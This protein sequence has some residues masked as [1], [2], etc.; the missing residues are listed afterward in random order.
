MA[1]VIGPTPPGIGRDESRDLAHARVDVADQPGLGA[2]DADVEHGGP[3][4]YVLRRDQP[5][6]AGRGH[7]D[8]GAAQVGREVAGA[9]VAERHGGVLACAGSAAGRAGDRR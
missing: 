8:V 3:G 6:H 2:G 4:T 1:R 5:G 9:G 7:D